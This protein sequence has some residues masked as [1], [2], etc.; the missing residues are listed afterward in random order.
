MDSQGKNLF[1]ILLDVLIVVLIINVLLFVMPTIGK[2]GD[3]LTSARMI[4]VAAEGKTTVSPDIA[5]TSFSVVSRGKNPEILTAD[6]NRKVDSAI[7]F[8][9]SQG[10]DS[11]DI[12]TTG[13]NLSPDYQYDKDSN[14]T[15]I[16]GYTLTQTVSVKIR[17]LKK[18][19]SVIGGLAPLGVNQ[20]SGISF[21]VDNDEKYL[22][23]ARTDAFTKAR[24]KAETMAKENGASLGRLLNISEYQSPIPYPYYSALGKG[25]AE[26][27]PIAAPTIEPGT[28]EIRVTV[29]LTYALN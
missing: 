6:N 22:E 5:E 13:Y 20:I 28:Q 21:T 12:K 3:S 7:Q 25:I 18:V 8:L 27:V 9:K 4:S 16:I 24:V 17:D 2:F 11:K 14:R 26:A 1:W 29:S 23:T 10:I 15:S 19:A